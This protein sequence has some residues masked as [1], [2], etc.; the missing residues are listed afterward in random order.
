MSPTLALGLGCGLALGGIFGLIWAITDDWFEALMNLLI[1]VTVTAVST[2]AACL[3]AYGL[4]G[5]GR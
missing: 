2:G 5:V 4:Q 3:I 1:L